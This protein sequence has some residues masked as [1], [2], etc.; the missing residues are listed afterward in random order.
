MR[1]NKSRCATFELIRL[2]KID[3]IAFILTINHSVL[4][5]VEWSSGQGIYN[6]T[7]PCLN[8]SLDEWKLS[9]M[10]TV[11]LEDKDAVQH[12]YR[13]DFHFK[14]VRVTVAFMSHS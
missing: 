14:A 1:L 9:K 6:G 7:L 13:F 4:I 11:S 2:S 5:V 12:Q 8:T 3:D 10:S